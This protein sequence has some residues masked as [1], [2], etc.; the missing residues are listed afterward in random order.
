ME[1]T[2]IYAELAI[3]NKEVQYIFEQKVQKWFHEK[4]KDR[5][6]SCCITPSL[7]MTDINTSVI[8]VLHSVGRSARCVAGGDE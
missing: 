2:K 1:G 5:I 7:E 4:L 6:C 8:T 3:L